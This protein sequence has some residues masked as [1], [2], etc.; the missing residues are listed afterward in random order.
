MI[1]LRVHQLIRPTPPNFKT[2][3]QSKKRGDADFLSLWHCGRNGV[4]FTNVL[5]FPLGVF[6]PYYVFS[7][8]IHSLA[9]IWACRI[10]SFSPLHCMNVF[11]YFKSQSQFPYTSYRAIPTATQVQSRGN[12]WVWRPGDMADLPGGKEGQAFTM[13]QLICSN[14]PCACAYPMW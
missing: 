2:L 11:F 4:S 12:K 7:W 3:W 13:H 10:K 9:W 14:C 1:F 5:I 6:S 8:Q